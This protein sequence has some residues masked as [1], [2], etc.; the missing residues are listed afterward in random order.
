M[1]RSFMLM[2]VGT[3]IVVQCTGQ[4]P[5][6]PNSQRIPQTLTHT[7]VVKSEVKKASALATAASDT[8]TNTLPACVQKDCNCSDFAHQKEAQ[9][10]LEAFPNDPHG[11]DRNKDGMAC[12]SLPD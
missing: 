5:E 12:E 10:V 1:L 2:I 3:T 8:S 7:P 4:K 6:L 11:L 9:A